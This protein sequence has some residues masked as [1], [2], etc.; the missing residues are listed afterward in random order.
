MKTALCLIISKGEEKEGFCEAKGE[1]CLSYH[2]LR[3]ECAEGGKRRETQ[4][5]TQTLSASPLIVI[6]L[7]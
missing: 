7:R 2:V 6:K 1:K 3:T 4:A 5:E